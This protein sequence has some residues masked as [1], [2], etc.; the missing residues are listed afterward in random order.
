M[1]DDFT[2]IISKDEKWKGGLFNK[3]R[4][5]SYASCMNDYDLVD[6]GYGCKTLSPTIER[7]KNLI[8]LRLDHAWAN[9]E[10]KQL[11]SESK[12]FYLKRWPS[13]Y[14]SL[15]LKTY[16][17]AYESFKNRAFRFQPMWFDHPMCIPFI[18]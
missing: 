4:V 2:N 12:T 9:I 18:I 7:H 15:L 8:Q 14:Y 17:Y 5:H 16:P 11:F 1:I 13:E 6:L 10:M 3:Y